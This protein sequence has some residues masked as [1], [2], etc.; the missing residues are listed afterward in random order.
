VATAAAVAAV[1]VAT[2][3]AAAVAVA[4]AAVA[5]VAAAAATGSAATTEP[6]ASGLGGSPQ[7]N[8]IREPLPVGL[9]AHGPRGALS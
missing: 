6:P 3:A 5:A 2:A 4:T 1:A 9:R 7:L 8:C